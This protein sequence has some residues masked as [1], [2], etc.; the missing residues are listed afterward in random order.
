M[1]K[2][3]LSIALV[4]SLVAAVE[5]LEIQ[6]NTNE[7]GIREG[8]QVPEGRMGHSL[9]KYEI[10]NRR[11]RTYLWMFG[12][13]TG[14]NVSNELW[15]F[16]VRDNVW[17]KVNT[18]DAP[19][20]RAGHVGC[21]LN[22]RMYIFG[23]I[24]E[25]QEVLNDFYSYHFRRN[26]F[27]KLADPPVKL[28]NVTGACVENRRDYVYIFG[29]RYEDEQPPV[30][31]TRPPA[32]ETEPPVN[33]V[34]PPANTTR[35]RENRTEH[36][37]RRIRHESPVVLRYDIRARAWE[38]LTTTGELNFNV[39]AVASFV[40]DDDNDYKI[41]IFG[42]IDPQNETMPND[43]VVLDLR[44]RRSEILKGTGPTP[45]GR[46][47]HSLAPFEDT[48]VLFGGNDGQRMLNDMWLFD[49][50]TRRWT[51]LQ[52]TGARPE[53]RSYHAT[54]KA[55]DYMYLVGGVNEQDKMLNDIWKINLEDVLRR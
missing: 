1:L 31:D 10:E 30:N 45:R 55:D 41:Y 12:G 25:N 43:L 16:G 39:G 27:V 7:T 17:E 28:T 29:F 38:E 11:E 6:R 23:G 50:Y 15:R 21:K 22:S 13:Y 33:D 49:P 9:V 32:N 35:N 20:P 24:G 3:I 46:V 18:S 19:S 4:I 8:R 48:L 2:S 42:G 37:S 34:E 51:E 54:T 36:E 26:R 53:P 14:K 44:S 52:I 40:E 47:G 5:W